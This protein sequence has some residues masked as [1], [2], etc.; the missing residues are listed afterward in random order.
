MLRTKLPEITVKELVERINNSDELV[1]IDIRRENEW[2]ATGVIEGS[3]LIT[4]VDFVHRLNSDELKNQL[5]N[6]DVV[7]I[8]RSGNRSGRMT[9]YLINEIK[10]NANVLNMYGGILEWKRNGLPV[11]NPNI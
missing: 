5:I 4:D 3:N 11:I 8:C 2:R 7:L 6:K 1:L 10:L 9:N